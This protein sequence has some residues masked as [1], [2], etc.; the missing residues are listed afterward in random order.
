MDLISVIVPVYNVQDYLH[1]CVDSILRQTY[2]EIE[3]ILIDDG[4]TDN[5]GKIC[6]EYK[7]ADN[8]IKVIHQSNQGQS[9]A[10]NSGIDKACGKW[11]CFIDSDDFVQDYYLEYLLSL[12]AK[13]ETKISQCGYIE[14]MDSDFPSEAAVITE[15]KWKLQDLYC[16]HSRL[17]R[18]TVWA[19]LFS[20]DLFQDYRFPA[21]K[22]FEDEDA[23]FLLAYKAG[24]IAVSNRHCYY[25]YQSPGST[26]RKERTVIR[27]DFVELFEKRIEL[28]RRDNERFM[29]EVTKKELCIRL[30]LNY[31]KGWINPEMRK[32]DCVKIYRIFRKFYDVLI[33]KNKMSRKEITALFIFR[34]FPSQFAFLE[35]R[36]MIIANEKEKRIKKR[37]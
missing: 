4:S 36:F 5:S 18:A 37:G 17:F 15:K 16:S 35:N 6:D 11:I 3:I 22:I 9:V 20:R 23:A 14:G 2:K 21:G 34:L 29:V 1:R 10:R 19:K 32:R 8:R 28:L 24:E 26:M 7:A 33:M 12:C 31:C 25:Y 30:M 13:F 27:L